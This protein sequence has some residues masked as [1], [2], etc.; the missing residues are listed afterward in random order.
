MYDMRKLFLL[1]IILMIISCGRFK[2]SD[3]PLTENEKLGNAI[4]EF[5]ILYQRLLTFKNT[6]EFH[7][8]GFEGDGII[9]GWLTKVDN[10]KENADS[11]LQ[12]KKIDVSS[13]KHLGI[14]YAE[15]K[16]VETDITSKIN[17]L[18][19]NA[20]IQEVDYSKEISSDTGTN[21]HNQSIVKLFSQFPEE[22]MLY[23]KGL[24]DN[25]VIHPYQETYADSVVD[26]KSLTGLNRVYSYVSEPT[27]MFFPAI[28][29]KNKGIGLVIFP[30]GG[31]K[32]IW[33]DK[34]GTDVA[35]WL[36]EQ[37]ITCMVVKYRTNRKDSDGD[38][39]IDFDD[40]KGAIYQDA[41]TSMH[42]MKEFADSLDFDKN[43][44]G[45]MGF[46]AGGW[47]V[48]RMVYKYY[49]GDYEWNPKFVA[50]IYHGNNLKLI[51]DVKDKEKLP[52][53]FMAVAQNDN[54]LT[55]EKVLPYLKM[56]STEVKNSELHIYP[57]GGHGFG[58]A[59]DEKTAVSQWKF[60]FVKWIDLIN[61]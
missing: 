32:N 15:S 27:Y 44:I 50:L 58:L 7:E 59:Y 34:E 17:E 60:E 5:K 48:E 28:K 36:S 29:E 35:F 19:G 38:Y 40:Y 45:M 52:P 22:K 41:R 47:L 18:F 51:K 12:S 25:P 61:K 20:L 46:S 3:Q 57:D 14:A 4:G 10:L 49:E 9:S 33:L 24:K 11:L 37:G 21:D 23:P 26:P 6:S 31:L 53:F 55:Y 56:V 54:K 42:I 1:P 30:G 8:H 39:I 43:K 2:N 16:G 13:L